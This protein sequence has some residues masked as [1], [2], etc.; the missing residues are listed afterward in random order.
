ML[1]I[2]FN[3]QPYFACKFSAPAH[4]CARKFQPTGQDWTGIWTRRLCFANASQVCKLTFRPDPKFAHELTNLPRKFAL[5]LSTVPHKFAC[6]VSR[7]LTTVCMQTS[8]LPLQVCMQP[9]GGLHANFYWFVWNDMKKYLEEPKS[10]L[11]RIHFAIFFDI[12]CLCQQVKR[13]GIA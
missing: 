11:K 2:D 4:A 9:L 12:N 10:H 5:K 6:K 13:Q 7:L 8:N 1:Y 3:P